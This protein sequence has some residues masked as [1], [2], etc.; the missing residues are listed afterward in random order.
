MYMVRVLRVWSQS[1]VWDRQG[2]RYDVSMLIDIT[3]PIHPGMAIYPNN[4]A[5]TFDRVQAATNGASTLTHLSLGSHTGTHIDAPSHITE[6]ALGV[7]TYSLDTLVGV[8]EVV[9]VSSVDSVITAADIPVTKEQRLLF[10]TKN[11]LG[12]VDTFDP[13]FVALDDSAAEELLRRGVTLV[14]IDGPS[15][16]KKGVKDNV[17]RLLLEAGV[18]IVESLWLPE[19]VAGRY[20]LVC[21]PLAV[22]GVDGAPVRAVVRTL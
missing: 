7:D 19:V 21:L 8:C 14:G 20:E 4:P 1:L 6:G 5:V 17:H 12:N 2:I 10:K 16:K 9:D 11:S 3:R 15:I 18:V 22:V 13:T